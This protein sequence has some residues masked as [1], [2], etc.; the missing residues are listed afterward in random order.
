M[1]REPLQAMH[2]I[3]HCQE[4]DVL[5]CFTWCSVLEFTS[6]LNLKL[7]LLFTDIIITAS[8]LC[9]HLDYAATQVTRVIKGANHGWR[10]YEGTRY[11]AIC[12]CTQ[13]L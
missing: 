5:P 9:A 10:N 1:H 3:M 4:I 6:Q 12:S 11:T 13:V 7:N 8:A 2:M